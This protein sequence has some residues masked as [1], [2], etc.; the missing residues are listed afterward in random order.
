[1]TPLS[2][3]FWAA[4][5]WSVVTSVIGPTQDG[6]WS[7]KVMLAGLTQVLYFGPWQPDTATV[8]S[9]PTPFPQ[10]DLKAA[11]PGGCGACSSMC[12]WGEGGLGPCFLPQEKWSGQ[13][14][15]WSSVGNYPSNKIWDVPPQKKKNHSLGQMIPANRNVQCY[16]CCFLFCSGMFCYLS[17]LGSA[18]LA[19]WVQWKVTTLVFM[20]GYR[21]PMLI[22]TCSWWW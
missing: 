7:H 3:D 14:W 21:A 10:M 18:R 11:W 16:L 4:S 22:F 2:P 1:M 15:T 13:L 19:I 20:L 12:G 8:T 6:S 5:Y 17:L 9:T